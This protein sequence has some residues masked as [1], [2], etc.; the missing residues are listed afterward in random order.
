MV[1]IRNDDQYS[2]FHYSVRGD[3]ESDK[4]TL[5]DPVRGRVQVISKQTYIYEFT[6]KDSHAIGSP[7]ITEPHTGA[8]LILRDAVYVQVTRVLHISDLASSFMTAIDKL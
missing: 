2:G 6:S 7:S 5:D 4:T 1:R 3:I 8:E